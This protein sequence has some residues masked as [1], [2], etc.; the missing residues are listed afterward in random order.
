MQKDSEIFSKVLSEVMQCTLCNE[1]LP[2]P[3]KPIIQGSGA[4][5]ILIIGQAPGLIAHNTN[6]PWND[7][8]GDRL[9]NWM[10]IDRN[11]FYNENILSIIPMGFCFPGYKNSA[12][13]PPRKECAPKW[14]ARLITSLQPVL[15]LYIGRYAQ[16][17][18]LPA[19]N[20]LTEAVERTAL[21]IG[22]DHIALPHPSGRNNRWLSK[23]PWFGNDAL[24]LLQQRI[25]HIVST[26]N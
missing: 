2:Y 17:Y 11:T 7:A 20:T 21:A 10:G 5:K 14:H 3:A 4:A 23:H 19:F 15:T 8:S 1:V 12:D 24:P 6:L 25:K 18:Y 9:R 16:Q 22:T 13:A 26:G